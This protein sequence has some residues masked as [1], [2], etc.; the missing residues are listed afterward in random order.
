MTGLTFGIACFD[1]LSVE[2]SKNL[3]R[4]SMQPG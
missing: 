1:L 2:V 3:D 4:S